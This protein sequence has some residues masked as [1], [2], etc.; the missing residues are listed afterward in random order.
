MHHALPFYGQHQHKFLRFYI[1]MAKLTRIPLVGRLVRWVANSYA[2]RGHHGY[3]LTLE[4]AE[5]IIDAS[6][7]VGLKPCSCRQVFHNCDAPVMAEILIGTGVEVFSRI[8]P[9]EFHEVSKEEAKNILRQCHQ[10][11][12]IHTIMRCQE[13]FYAICNCCTCC[14]V[15]TRLRRNYKIEYALVRNKNVVEDFRRQQL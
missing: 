15:P 2:K 11:H 6:K 7:S 5:Q 10:K 9:D 8:K 1:C 3:F 4:Q 14:C 12:M 13:N